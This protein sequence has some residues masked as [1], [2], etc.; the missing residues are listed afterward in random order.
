MAPKHTLL[1]LFTIAILLR[2][3]VAALFASSIARL[4]NRYQAVGVR[5]SFGKQYQRLLTCTQDCTSYTP[6]DQES[7]LAR[8]GV[9]FGNPLDGHTLTIQRITELYAW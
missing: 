4:L 8:L 9:Q 3:Y 7:D 6:G 5:L 2:V 1:V